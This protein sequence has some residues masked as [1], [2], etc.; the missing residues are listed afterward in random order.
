[1]TQCR[2]HSTR[3][4]R[5]IIEVKETYRVLREARHNVGPT[6]HETTKT[7]PVFVRHFSRV[8]PEN[9]ARSKPKDE[10]KRDLLLAPG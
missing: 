6:V 7:P 8:G 9:G 5:P 1:M 10:Q 2:S 3:K 4:K